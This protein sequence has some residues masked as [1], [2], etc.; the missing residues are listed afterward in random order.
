MACDGCLGLDSLGGRNMA[1]EEAELGEGARLQGVR[2][3]AL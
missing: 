1:M 3:G 2:Q